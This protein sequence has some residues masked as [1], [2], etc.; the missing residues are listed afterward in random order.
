MF[1]QVSPPATR[2]VILISPRTL[3]ATVD[4][5]LHN[6]RTP[7]RRL[8]DLGSSDRTQQEPGAQYL[9]RQVRE[10]VHVKC[11]YSRTSASRKRE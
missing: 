6:T 5:G 8:Q 3:N 11:R 7:A 10:C 4:P 2:N 9:R 1:D